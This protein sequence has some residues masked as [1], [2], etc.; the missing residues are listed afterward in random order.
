MN[1]TKNELPFPKNSIEDKYI[2]QS[3]LSL[4]Y[5]FFI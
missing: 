4:Y 5:Y 2:L 1:L 3:I